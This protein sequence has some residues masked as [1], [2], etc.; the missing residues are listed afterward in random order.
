MSVPQY[1]LSDHEQV[2][3]EN[4]FKISDHLI[5]LISSIFLFL[6]FLKNCECKIVKN[7]RD[8]IL[9][10]KIETLACVRSARAMLMENLQPD[11]FERTEV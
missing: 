7:Q 10:Y 3:G 11:G 8:K 2:G 6:I 5:I 1:S 9:A 4:N